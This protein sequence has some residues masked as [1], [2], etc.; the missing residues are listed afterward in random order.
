M[1]CCSLNRKDPEAHYKK[2]AA[3]YYPLGGQSNPFLKQVFLALLPEDLQP[4]IQ[5]MMVTL[6]KEI[7]TTI[8][9]K[10]YQL[11]LATNDQTTD[12]KFS[13]AERNL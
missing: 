1:R 8:L 11:A 12:K 10:I 2:M 7:S 9:K 6:R 5:R 4:K 13:K 3:K